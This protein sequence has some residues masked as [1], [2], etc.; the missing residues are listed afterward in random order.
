MSNSSNSGLI[1]SALRFWI[2][3]SI[4]NS[5]DQTYVSAQ[6]LVWSEL[7]AGCYLIS[8]CLLILRP[9]I[10]R[11]ADS[12]L[13]QSFRSNTYGNRGT[14]SPG[15]GSGSKTSAATGGSYPNSVVGEE[16]LP[17]KNK[18]SDDIEMVNGLHFTTSK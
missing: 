13:I 3:Y 6:L 16:L 8:A 12:S 7:E 4:N 10:E 11:I 15:R 5:D 1:F 17:S 2:T 18:N 14:G 9:L